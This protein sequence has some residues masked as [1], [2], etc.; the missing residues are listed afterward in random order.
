M[1][2]ENS[3]IAARVRNLLNICCDALRSWNDG[4]LPAE[5]GVFVDENLIMGNLQSEGKKKQRKSKD[6]DSI[7][8]DTIAQPLKV[9]S[10]ATPNKYEDDISSRV[11]SPVTPKSEDFAPQIQQIK[12][13]V[14][15]R[16]DEFFTPP[17]Q[18]IKSA[19][20]STPRSEDDSV[21][22][23]FEKAHTPAKR[24]APKPPTFSAQVF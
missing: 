6:A 18:K 10:P 12:T 7:L 13:P 2:Y 15:P 4:L 19:V 21:K 23:P 16:S 9:K 5:N 8:Q 1:D 24:Q 17:T 3:A 11:K 14:N 20:T 22:S